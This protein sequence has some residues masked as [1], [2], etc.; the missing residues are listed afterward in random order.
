MRVLDEGESAQRRSASPDDVAD[1]QGPSPACIPP[2]AAASIH[3]IVVTCDGVPLSFA[4]LSLFAPGQVESELAGAPVRNWVAGDLQV[5]ACARAFCDVHGAFDF[6]PELSGSYLLALEDAGARTS[7]RFHPVTVR[8]EAAPVRFVVDR[9]VLEVEVGSTSEGD[10]E[11]EG[12][13][14]QLLALDVV[15]SP[16]APAERLDFSRDGSLWTA[17]VTPGRTYRLAWFVHD[18]PLA[19]QEVAIVPGQSR[20]RLEFRPPERVAGGTLHVRLLDEAGQ[21]A[22]G[23]YRLGVACLDPWMPLTELRVTEDAHLSLPPGRFLVSLLGSD[24]DV[25]RN[26]GNAGACTVREGGDVKLDL[27][28]VRTGRL[29]VE[30]REESPAET[31]SV[32]PSSPGECRAH[33]VDS[34]GRE[35]PLRFWLPPSAPDGWAGGS[36]HPWRDEDCCC[37]P[38]PALTWSLSAGR[39]YRGSD[40]IAP[41]AYT[42]VVV[43]PQHARLSVPVL[44]HAEETTEVVLHAPR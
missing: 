19:W 15:A 7:W 44:V 39:T 2:G 14:G 41:G 32:A 29:D 4:S 13:E 25:L 42:L 5:A 21:P 35:L 38:G 34:E 23:L 27:T 33:L 9:H 36:A 17:Q 26:L 12:D 37:M 1:P 22:E 6:G 43:G 20:T 16:G 24:G 40:S 30:L 8:S 3:G 18:R 28:L 10:G 31:G 11:I